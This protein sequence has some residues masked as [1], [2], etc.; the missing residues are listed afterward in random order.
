MDHN[1]IPVI[2]NIDTLA[3]YYF[4]LG[5]EHQYNREYDKAIETFSEAIKLDS[6]NFMNYR[7]RSSVYKLKGEYDVAIKDITKSIE[8]EP[9]PFTAY[10]DRGEIYLEKGDY[11]NAVKDFEKALEINPTH[12]EVLNKK[13]KAEASK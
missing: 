9:Y 8:L 12:V 6:K 5:Y 10:I 2:S 7:Q 4:N 3:D 13:I 11:D 1:Y